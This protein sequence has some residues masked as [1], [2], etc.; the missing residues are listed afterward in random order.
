MSD[1]GAF[2]TPAGHSAGAGGAPVTSMGDEI[3]PGA[4]LDELLDADEFAGHPSFGAASMLMP[5]APVPPMH[6]PSSSSGSLPRGSRS[7]K[8]T[9]SA[10]RSA[11]RSTAAT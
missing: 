9:T 11:P 4:F 10:R 3:P 2:M 8:T 6:D 5:Q 7:S 1:F